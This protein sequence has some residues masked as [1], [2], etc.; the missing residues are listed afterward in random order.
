LA[1]AATAAGTA[2]GLAR[3]LGPVMPDGRVEAVQLALQ[4]HWLA[5]RSVARA[6]VRD[7]W[8]LSVLALAAGLRRPLG[9][10]VAVAWASRLAATRGSP[11]ARARNWLLGTVDDVAYGTGVWTG[12]W[13]QR[14]LRCLAPNLRAGPQPITES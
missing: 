7:W 8:P 11:R 12:A 6:S 2:A 3:K 13:R 5:G 10:L 9:I 14:S 4:G 1:A